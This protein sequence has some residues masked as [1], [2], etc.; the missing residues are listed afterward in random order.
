[1]TTTDPQ[2]QNSSTSSAFPPISKSDDKYPKFEEITIVK[3]QTYLNTL[4]ISIA[5]DVQNMEQQKN[6]IIQREMLNY[7][8][9]TNHF[10][11]I[12]EESLKAKDTKLIQIIRVEFLTVRQ[13][14]NRDL[15]PEHQ[16]IKG[17]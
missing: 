6:T 5:D 4:G 16:T 17:D 14:L 12:Y 3:E 15:V 7:I 13:C 11:I 8:E 1:M 9:S 2:H 10:M